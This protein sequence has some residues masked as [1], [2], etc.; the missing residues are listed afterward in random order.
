MTPN[1]P[2][3][4]LARWL[5]PSFDLAWEQLAVFQWDREPRPD[6]FRQREVM[7]GKKSFLI[8]SDGWTEKKRRLNLR[9]TRIQGQALDIATLMCYPTNRPDLLPVYAFEWVVVGGRGHAMVCDV[10]TCGEQSRLAEELDRD[11][12]QLGEKWAKV[13]QPQEKPEWFQEICRP[14][15]QFFATDLDGLTRA[16]E[17]QRDYLATTL[18]HY[19]TQKGK[20]ISGGPDHEDTL[21]Y[22]RHHSAHS[23]GKKLLLKTLGPEDSRLFLD[24]FHFGP[25]QGI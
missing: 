17:M 24:H 18:S 14:H 4:E 16:F 20:D 5:N 10:E 22:K 3:S 1:F 23:P 2:H 15:A 19:Y 6:R 21:H 13:F 9:W 8:T 25:S 7:D 12:Q 11:F